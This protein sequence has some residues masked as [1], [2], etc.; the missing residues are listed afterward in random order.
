[1]KVWEIYLSHSSFHSSYLT[2]GITP[3]WVR[4]SVSSQIKYP[5]GRLLGLS[6][7]GKWDGGTLKGAQDWK[8]NYLRT[9]IIS[10]LSLSSRY[11]SRDW[12]CTFCDISQEKKFC[13]T[14]SPPHISESTRLGKIQCYLHSQVI[15]FPNL[16]H[17]HTWKESRVVIWPAHRKVALE[18]QGALRSHLWEAGVGSQGTSQAPR[19]FSPS[20]P[21]HTLRLQ[22][23]LNVC[24]LLYLTTTC[25]QRSSTSSV[26]KV[27]AK[28]V[29]NSKK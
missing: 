6:D 12:Q 28:G 4:T 1:M 13:F 26:L 8:I 5:S 23:C 18:L 2:R 29:T 27:K 22:S 19:L 10:P 3:T 9:T 21:D 24:I 14:F 25:P 16:P 11:I 17:N 7:W 15:S 20:S